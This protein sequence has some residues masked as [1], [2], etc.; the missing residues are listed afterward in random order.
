[1]NGPITNR[2]GQKL[3][4]RFHPAAQSAAPA[5]LVIIGHGVTAHLD[6]PFVK[7]LAEG[8]AAAGLSALRFSYSG[9]GESEGDFRDSCISREVEDLGSVIDAATAAGY[10]VSYVGHSMGGAVG[11]L[12]AAQDKRI[13]FL[14]SLAGMVETKRF[15]ET[16]FGMVE[17][18]KGDMWDEPSCPLSS[19]F[20][21]DLRSIGSTAGAA[22]SLTVPFLMVHGLADDLVPIDESR[23]L[24]KAGAGEPGMLIELDADHVFSGE[25][26]ADMVR[27]VIHW[28]LGRVTGS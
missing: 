24:L 8:L 6:R 4:Y 9:N 3:D 18:D 22:G 13:R 28:L 10:E 27:E 1:M 26:T 25:A 20:M 17:P 16:E 21:N 11:V 15:A 19:T 14:V 12:R 7:A 2:H 23:A 5:H